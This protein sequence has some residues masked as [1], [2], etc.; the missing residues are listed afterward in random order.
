MKV[1]TQMLEAAYYNVLRDQLAVRR[2]AIVCEVNPRIVSQHRQAI[3]ELSRMIDPP[4][5]K[6]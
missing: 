5:P 2:R 3:F 6:E 1:R 4:K